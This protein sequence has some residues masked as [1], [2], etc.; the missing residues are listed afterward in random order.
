[1]CKKL[2][3]LSCVPV[4]GLAV[5][6][7]GQVPM[8][9]CTLDDEAS[10]TA[11]GGY[12]ADGPV[13]F[14][15][16]AIDNALAGNN[17]GYARWNNSQVQTIFASW[18]NEA[19]VTVDLY[20]RG[21]HWS[22]HSGN[23]GFW[24]VVKRSS[25]DRY[26]ILSVMG[27][28]P[29]RG[30]LRLLIRDS[31]GEFKW[32]LNGR[33]GND[34]G[35]LV[36][37]ADDTT[38]RM[39]LRQANGVLE[40]YLDGGEFTNDTPTFST[41]TD[42]LTGNDALPVGWTWDFVPSSSDR[43]MNVGRRAIFDGLLET[44]EWVDNVRVYNGYWTPAEIDAG[45]LPVAIINAVPSSGWAPLT[46]DFDGTDSY[47]TDATDVITLYEWDFTDDGT[48]DLSGDE[49]AAGQ[50]S[51]EYASAGTYTCRLTVTDDE[52]ETGSTT[53][54]I[55]VYAP[56]PPELLTVTDMLPTG[57]PLTGSQ[58]LT[59]ITTTGPYTVT[60][61]LGPTVA[62]IDGGTENENDGLCHVGAEHALKGL[63]LGRMLSGGAAGGRWYFPVAINGD[64]TGRPEVF[65]LEHAGTQD[66]FDIDLLTNAAGQAVVVAA[67]VPVRSIDYYPT[68]T[69]MTSFSGGIGGVGI[70]LDAIAPP[71]SDITGVQLLAGTGLDPCLVAAVPPPGF[72]IA[73][74][75]V[76]DPKTVSGGAPFPVYF[77]A[78]CGSY[79]PDGDVTY[80]W[81]F[82]SDGITDA[83]GLTAGYTYPTA[84][85]FT[86][87]LKVT[88][89]DLLTGLDTAQVNVSG[90]NPKRTIID[91][92]W[93]GDDILTSITT[94]YPG[95]APT[96]VTADME[97]PP[98]DNDGGDPPD[99]L[100]VEVPDVTEEVDLVGLQRGSYVGSP[101]PGNF[102]RAFFGDNVVV[103][104]D[105]TDA[106]EIFVIERTD[107]TTDDFLFQVLTS[108]PGEPPVIA[109]QVQV[110]SGDYADAGGNR[111]GVGL[112]L[113]SLGVSSVWGVQIP[114]NDGLG[115]E[116]GI[117]LD[118]VAAITTSCNPVVFADADRDLDVD[119]DDFAV[120]Q[121][122]YTGP[123]NP[124][125]PTGPGYCF[126]FD[127]LD[128][129]DVDEAD[130]SA[131]EAC[132]TGP[133]IP[134]TQESTPGCIPN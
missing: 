50:V 54:T 44:G 51:H 90:A 96:F 72:T 68:A 122:C 19:G 125:L 47:D 106:P 20:F 1:M 130:Y 119:Q 99:Y 59:S 109:A 77:S 88:D 132:A 8:W 58:V 16:G 14:V 107:A 100:Y 34:N 133:G 82:T 18:N 63:E 61:L 116:T 78:S 62:E 52:A 97:G 42:L 91:L 40:M 92:V 37:L 12:I 3:C 56:G 102:M 105:G 64:G 46:V 108:G 104:P 7:F 25:G 127:R 43:Q 114:G 95:G 113:D 128:D 120:F 2:L 73:P 69:E 60:D 131:F 65:V 55:N 98:D 45:G 71:V 94:E 17:M 48:V 101:G 85:T 23:S 121:R 29:G 123:D 67:T 117:D 129:K 30:Y 93:D 79:D 103:I 112:D 21:D 74:I 126:C 49:V 110:Y 15:P 4:L 38:Y 75:A 89:D 76:I 118:V 41:A 81:D 84:G 53:A 32:W 28:D 31:G 57:G 22:T 86:A 6:A 115:G 70:D 80:E 36:T 66:T 26:L 111:G 9:Q 10:I 13:S 35:P 27:E 11:T 134:W 87:T 24:S 83:T 5:S 124:P 33:T 39:T